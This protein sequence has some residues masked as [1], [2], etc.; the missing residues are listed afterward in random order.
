M[1][2]SGVSNSLVQQ[3]GN[4]STQVGDAISIKML[5]KSLDIQASQATRLIESVAKSM[6]E[7]GSRL[8]RHIDIRV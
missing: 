8:G 4:S 1:D 6:P 3:I 2:I 7:S 5:R